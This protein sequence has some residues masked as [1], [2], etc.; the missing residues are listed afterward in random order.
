MSNTLAILWA[1]VIVLAAPIAGF[2]ARRPLAVQQKSRSL[3]Y[4]GSAANL[5]LIGT[6]TGVI[7]VTCGGKAIRGL[8]WTMSLPRFLAWSLGLTIASILISVAVFVLR[9]NLNRPLSPIVRSLLPRTK[10]ER[11]TFLVL[12]LLVGVV[13][14]FVFRGF[15]FSTINR[16]AASPLIAASVVT[17]AFALQHGIQDAIGIVRAF[18]LGVALLIPVVATG[19]L[20]PSI[21]AH[22]FVDAFSGLYGRVALAPPTPA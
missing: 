2:L 13:E 3:V 11:V 6:I 1:A 20:L 8:N 5:L 14:E 17:L 19:S 22:A 4:A 15:A 16:F 21:I 10:S 9:R 18:V 12:C 7:D